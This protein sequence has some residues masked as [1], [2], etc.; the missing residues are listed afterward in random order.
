MRKNQNQRK[1][2]NKKLTANAMR[3]VKEN[4]TWDLVADKFG[5]CS[6][7]DLGCTFAGK[8]I[9]GAVILFLGIPYYISDN[10]PV[11]HSLREYVFD[12]I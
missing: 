8:M 12:R 9:D 1:K 11:L 7:L 5:Q 4:F 6:D 3:F 2:L 10:V